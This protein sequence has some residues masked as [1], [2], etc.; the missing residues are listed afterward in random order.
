MPDS[1]D[2]RCVH[3][4]AVEQ[5]RR[6][7]EQTDAYRELSTLYRAL[8][9]PTRVRI[10]HVLLQQEMCTCDLALVLGVSDSAVSQHLRILRNL[11]LVRPRRAGKIVYY[12][13]DDS[14]VVHLVQVGLEHIGHVEA[15]QRLAGLSARVS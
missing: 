11:K 8:A 5:G 2:V 15:A 4:E 10:V 1:C 13:L 14:H 12:S 9:D 6:L 3:P 7:L